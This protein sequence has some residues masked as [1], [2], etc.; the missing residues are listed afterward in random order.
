MTRNPFAHWTQ[1]N[2]EQVEWL[3]YVCSLYGRNPYYYLVLHPH[4]LHYDSVGAHVHLE[5]ETKRLK[6]HEREMRQKY[7]K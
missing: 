1:Q 5:A 2:K 3:N 4:A 7:G 6:A